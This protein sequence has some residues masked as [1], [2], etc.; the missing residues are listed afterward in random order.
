MKLTDL[1]AG[2]NIQLKISDSDQPSE[3]KTL[4]SKIEW[5][6]DD[7]VFIIGAPIYERNVYPLNV[8]SVVN[9]YVFQIKK[10]TKE[11]DLYVCKAEV[12]E[13]KNIQGIPMLKMKALS[14]LNRIQRRQ[15]Y[16]YECML[17][18]EYREV[19]E[20]KSGH[21]T[22]VKETPMLK[23]LTKDIS[24]G[25]LCIVLEEKVE[26]G[27]ILDMIVELEENE[28]VSFKGKVIRI[29]RTLNSDKYKYEAGIVFQTIDEKE[30]E[31][32]IK[33]IFSEQRKLI[34]KGLI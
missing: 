14:S 7:D 30:R 21:Q 17:P 4:A 33:F 22:D 2:T 16:R 25:G 10:R 24:G 19:K 29:D 15:F 27:T 8:G 6:E 5:V 26:K 28:K 34:E 9:V 13:R 11:T 12:L 32:I 1:L 23:T 3:V 31:K 20:K 18:V